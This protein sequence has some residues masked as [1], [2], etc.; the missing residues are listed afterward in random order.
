MR[1]YGQAAIDAGTVRL[2]GVEGV[3]G[4]GRGNSNNG[5]SNGDGGEM[6]YGACGGV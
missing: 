3:E 1:T 5:G 4:L 6:H 2:E